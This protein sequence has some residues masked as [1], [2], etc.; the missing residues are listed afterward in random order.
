MALLIKLVVR[1]MPR[2]IISRAMIPARHGQLA[3]SQACEFKLTQRRCVQN[4]VGARRDGP[5][6]ARAGVFE[7]CQSPQH[8]SDTSEMK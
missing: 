2:P 5:E 1:A 4:S 7:A 6:P 3:T 8:V